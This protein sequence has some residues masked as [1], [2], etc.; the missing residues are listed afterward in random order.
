MTKIIGMFCICN[1]FFVIGVVGNINIEN[2][3]E[4]T[5]IDLLYEDTKKSHFSTNVSFTFLTT[6]CVKS[7]INSENS[8]AIS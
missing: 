7:R 8:N 5:K 4:C 6:D 1:G 3:F 2:V